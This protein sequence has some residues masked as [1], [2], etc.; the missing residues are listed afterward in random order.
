MRG[1]DG[2][3]VRGKFTPIVS[4]HVPPQRQAH[5]FYRAMEMAP[6]TESAH[7]EGGNRRRAESRPADQAHEARTGRKVKIDEGLKKAVWFF[8]CCGL[9]DERYS[10]DENSDRGQRSRSPRDAPLFVGS[11]IPPL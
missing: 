8:S 5:A 6:M 3:L 2:L 9:W 11:V 7:D 1:E 10:N 4:G